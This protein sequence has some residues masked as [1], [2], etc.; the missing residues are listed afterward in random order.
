MTDNQCMPL[1]STL[2]FL[3]PLSSITHFHTHC[4]YSHVILYTVHLSFLR[5]TFTH[6]YPEIWRKVFSNDLKE[7]TYLRRHLKVNI[8]L[9]ISPLKDD[10]VSLYNNIRSLLIELV[11]FSLNE[12]ILLFLDGQSMI[13]H[14]VQYCHNFKIC[15]LILKIARYH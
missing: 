3:L 15:S 6:Y 1:V 13:A 11:L 7:A 2:Y 5:S 14:L 9:F 4:F 10:I 8:I 12:M